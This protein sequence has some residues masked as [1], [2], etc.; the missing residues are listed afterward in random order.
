MPNVCANGKPVGVGKHEDFIWLG[1]GRFLE[2]LPVP[3]LGGTKWTGIPVLFV[4]LIVAAV[5]FHVLMRYTGFGRAVYAI[6]GNEAAAR[7]AGINVYRQ[8]LLMYTLT[9]AAAGLAGV[10]LAARTTS[11]NPIN[12]SGFE[13]QA[14]T[15]V[16]LG[17]AATIGGYG[18]I[19]GTILAFILVGVLNNG[20]NLIGLDTFYQNVALGSLLISAVALNQWRQARAERAR[21]RLTAR[22][23]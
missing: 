12:G 13:L 1:S 20:M 4:I 2:N 22:Q 21:T 9:G 7:L 23:G 14:I 8:K 19:M 17:G 5:F 15:S 3:E 18:T 11:G 10:L 16:F 6:G